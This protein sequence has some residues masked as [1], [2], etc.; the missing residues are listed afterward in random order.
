MRQSLKMKSYFASKY[1]SCLLALLEQSS[2]A[3]FKTSCKQ[4]FTDK[5][6]LEENNLFLSPLPVGSLFLS[7][8]RESLMFGDI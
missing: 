5:Q 2:I 8:S 1:G 6:Q 7:T 4:P 3:H